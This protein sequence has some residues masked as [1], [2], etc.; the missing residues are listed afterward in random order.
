MSKNTRLVH[1]GP[2]YRKWR[3]SVLKENGYFCSQCGNLTDL[4]VDHILPSVNHPELRYNTNNGRILC[5]QCRVRDMLDSHRKGKSL[6][7]VRV[8]V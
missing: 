4:T 6:R 7:R 8:E 2:K 5:E 1:R 3:E